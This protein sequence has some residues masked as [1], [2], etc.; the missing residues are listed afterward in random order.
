MNNIGGIVLVVAAMAAF[1]LED[2]FIKLLSQSLSTGEVILLLGAMGTALFAIGARIKR[3]RIWARDAWQ[4]VLLMRAT[5][6]GLAAM[7][8]VTALARVEIS[9]VA[10][11]FQAMP[12]AVTMGAALFMG[13]TVGWRR[14]SAIGLG[15][16][17]VLLIIRP[18]L[19]GFNA[20]T[21]YVLVAVV[22]ISFRDL[23]TRRVPRTVGTMTVSFQAF[24][25]TVLTGGLLIVLSDAPLR[26]PEGSA[27]G[28]LIGASLAGTLGVYG[29]IQAMRMAEA[30]AVQPFR[31]S[32]LVF[33]IAVGILVF[34]ER[35]DALTYL[36]SAIIVGAGLYSVLR[37]ARLARQA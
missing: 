21:G 23:I 14:W 16:C 7:A 26:A 28:F 31:Y 25:A 11:V 13:E 27:Y 9:V 4:P 29:I 32:R 12:L 30:S 33:S 34:G 5:A 10:A 19:D 24:A 36:G 2:M 35:P 15:F 22:L 3:E 6:E 1:A 20:D 37:E 17:G 18:G 8:F